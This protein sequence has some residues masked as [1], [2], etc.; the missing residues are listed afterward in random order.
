MASVNVQ[1]LVLLGKIVFVLIIVLV[2]LSWIA[3]ALRLWVRFK[4]TKSPGW[5]DAAM[6]V[7]LVLFNVYCAIIFVITFRSADGELF[8]KKDLRVSLM[9]VQLA[10]IFYILTTTTLKISLGLFFLRVLTKRWQTA[11]FHAILGISAIYGLFYVSITILQCGNP[12]RLAD[13]FMQADR[14]LP[15]ALL[16]TSGYVY[17]I[18]NIVADWTFV[19][20]P[21]AILIDSDIDRRAKISVSIVMGLG[22]IGSVASIFRLFYLE[23]LLIGGGALSAASVKVTI[24]ATAEP[25]TGIIA[26]SVAIWRPLFRKMAVD[27]RD[28]VGVYQSR[29]ASRVGPMLDPGTQSQMSRL[30]SHP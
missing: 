23:G 26:A 2:L 1:E 21:I 9:Y 15:K 12:A 25:G 4:I 24:W 20:I 6:V 16:L 17:G 30:L 14:C 11:I 28:K 19:L 22:A 10:E 5:D 3:V 13:S 27:V 18:L 8:H 7:T 29:K